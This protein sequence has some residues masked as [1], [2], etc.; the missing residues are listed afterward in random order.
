MRFDNLLG[1]NIENIE[2]EPQYQ[3]Y[4]DSNKCSYFF[5][6]PLPYYNNTIHAVFIRFNEEKTISDININLMS[7]I[8]KSSYDE[9]VDV[10]GQPNHILVSDRIVHETKK[11]Y[12]KKLGQTTKKKQ[13]KAR[14]GTFD[15]NPTFIIWDKENFKIEV[16]MKYEKGI[17][18][19][20]F[21]LPRK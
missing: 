21:K 19:I 5:E 13:T 15:E 17:S 2:L 11:T 7:L 1:Q 18:E 3:K 8:D 10:Y 14:Q 4:C 6:S 9:M 20:N 12:N 16:L